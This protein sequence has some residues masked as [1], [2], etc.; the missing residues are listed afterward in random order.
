MSPLQLS[1]CPC[2][3]FYLSKTKSKKKQRKRRIPRIFYK[4]TF[5]SVIMTWWLCV[6]SGDWRLEFFLK[7][8]LLSC[9]TF[10]FSSYFYFRVPISTFFR[11]WASSFFLVCS[12]WKSQLV[13]ILLN[14]YL[15]LFFLSH[16]YS[17]TEIQQPLST[18]VCPRYAYNALSFCLRL[19]KRQF[20]LV[21]CEW[22]RLLH[23]F[24][25]S[26]PMSRV[27]VHSPVHIFIRPQTHSLIQKQRIHI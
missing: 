17:F 24:Q 11:S 25:L 9:F 21:P 15:L 27:C 13:P 16:L 4:G 7:S 19:R 23:F 5:S 18:R 20:S 10:W 26:T 22:W 8:S 6:D 2:V 1:S 12:F 14:I 3:P